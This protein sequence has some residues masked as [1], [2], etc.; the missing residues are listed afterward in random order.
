MRESK[1]G[2]VGWGR[3]LDPLLEDWRAF[4][5]KASAPGPARAEDIRNFEH[6]SCLARAGH[7]ISSATRPESFLLDSGRSGPSPGPEHGV[8]CAFA[9]LDSA[10]LRRTISDTLS[11]VSCCNSHS[12]GTVFCPRLHVS[13]RVA[14]WPVAII[15]N[16]EKQE[17]GDFPFCGRYITRCR[18]LA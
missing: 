12:L 17:A 14:L 6:P 5:G 4:L 11:P 15:S 18:I 9:G 10:L 2:G 3:V 16:G 1:T 7:G 13:P 8:S